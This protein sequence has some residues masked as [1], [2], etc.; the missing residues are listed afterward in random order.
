MKYKY[1]LLF[2]AKGGPSKVARGFSIGLALEM[3]T[4]PTFGLAA[5]LIIPL[6]Y[7]MRSSLAGA[8]VG[9]VFG[10]IIYVPVAF[11]VNRR[12][13]NWLVP[14]NIDKYI[15]FL[16]NWLETIV[17]SEINLIVGGAIVGL[18]LGFM[19]YLPV[20]ILLETYTHRRK[21]KRRKRKAQLAAVEV[22]VQ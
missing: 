6:V 19:T 7:L 13:G 9:F 11:F 21:E 12:I 3:I 22:D 4:L 15:Q 16:P 5:V 2:R 18:L 1:K 20:R 8:L 14:E 10:K 17:K